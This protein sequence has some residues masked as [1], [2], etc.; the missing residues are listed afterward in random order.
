MELKKCWFI[1]YFV[2]FVETSYLN[3]DMCKFE[4]SQKEES[5]AKSADSSKHH[6]KFI[7]FSPLFFW[8]R[9]P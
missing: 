2:M 5:R 6:S 9:F 4:S 1:H 3:T 8:I 7:T